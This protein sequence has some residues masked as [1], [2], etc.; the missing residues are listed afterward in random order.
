MLPLKTEFAIGIIFYY[1]E[2]QLG[3]DFRQFDP[4]LHRQRCA[5]RIMKIRKN[6]KKRGGFSAVCNSF[7][8]R[9]LY[10]F[11]DKSLV[12]NHHGMELCLV[13]PPGLDRSQVSWSSRQHVGSRVNEDPPDQI[14]RLL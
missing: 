14:K 7:L 3:S 2:V 13:R 5:G 1:R 6:I 12:I 10:F 8:V 9:T 11:R 4:P